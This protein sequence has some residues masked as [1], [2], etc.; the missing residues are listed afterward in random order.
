M[1][2][3]Y[4]DVTWIGILLLEFTFKFLKKV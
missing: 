2:H 4:L 3:E 1:R